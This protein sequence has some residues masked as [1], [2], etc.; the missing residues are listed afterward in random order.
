MTVID[1]ITLVILANRRSATRSKEKKVKYTTELE[2]EVQTL[3]TQATDLATEVTLIEKDA[4]GLSAE[5][6]ELKL[7]LQALEEQAKLRDALKESLRNDV[8]RL[9]MECRLPISNNGS[10]GS[11]VFHLF[12]PHIQNLL[13]QQFQNQN[14][15]SPSG[16]P[17]QQQEVHMP[18]QNQASASQMPSHPNCLGFNERP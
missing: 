10:A 1:T 5:N 14:Q 11:D 9:R 4:S 8:N 13:Q 3:K 2:K 17:N 12:P 6:K 15:A 18:N 7:R 16:Q